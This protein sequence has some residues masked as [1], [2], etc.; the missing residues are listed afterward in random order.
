MN[1]RPKFRPEPTGFQMTPMIDV[2]FLLLSFFLM[3]SVYSVWEKEIDISLPTAQTA[4]TPQ[5]LPGEIIINIVKDGSVVVNGRPLDDA[6]LGSLLKRL[7]EMFPGQPVLL[8][9]DKTTQYD[10]VIHVLDLCRKADIWNISFATGI[11]EP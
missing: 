8:R 3:T 2:T 11:P 5:R 9:A 10:H 6:A 4:T 7:V 1:F